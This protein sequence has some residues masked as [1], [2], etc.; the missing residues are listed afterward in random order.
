MRFLAF[1]LRLQ[2]SGP[3]E[4]LRHFGSHGLR[5]AYGQLPARSGRYV[6]QDPA[7]EV[8]KDRYDV[9]KIEKLDNSAF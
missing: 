1:F 7:E 4:S 2:I 5:S 8:W 3:Q 9:E 6:Y